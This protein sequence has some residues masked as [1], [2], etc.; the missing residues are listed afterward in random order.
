VQCLERSALVAATEEKRKKKNQ[1][2]TTVRELRMRCVGRPANARKPTH[3]VDNH[4]AMGSVYLEAACAELQCGG[5]T[6]L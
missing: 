3:S 6:S 1:Q 5:P 4:I 2:K